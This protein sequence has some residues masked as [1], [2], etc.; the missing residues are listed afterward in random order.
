[1]Y[2]MKKS[3]RKIT[4]NELLGL[5]REEVDKIKQATLNPDF[6]PKMKDELMTML[7]EVNIQVGRKDYK[8]PDDLYNAIAK[9]VRKGIFELIND[10][11][12]S[13]KAKPE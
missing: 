5:I 2:I 11:E 13:K 4:T 6:M 9:R 10:Y 7:E 1:M 3:V 12:A 8:V